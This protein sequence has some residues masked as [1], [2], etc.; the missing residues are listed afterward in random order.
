[1]FRQASGFT[2]WSR[3]AQDSLCRDY[4]VRSDLITVIPPGVRLDL[5]PFG[6]QP[7]RARPPGKPRVL[8]VGGD[9]ERKGGPLLLACMHAGLAE[10]CELDIV[11]SRPIPERPGVRAHYGLS[12][13]DPRLLAL[14]RDAD[15][16]AMPTQGDCLAVVLGEAMAAGL[17]VVTTTVAA[18]PEN[19]DDGR[20]GVLIPPADGDALGRALL[21]L[22]TDQD[23]RQR[24]GQAGRSIAE[25]RYDAARNADR[26]A[27]VVERAIMRWHRRRPERPSRL[28]GGG[29]S[30]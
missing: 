27:D 18:Q 4:G 19:V 16:F 11:T 7:R 1:V 2:V 10:W 3:W 20:S 22:A 12:P 26:I 17:P 13:N 8:F 9:F 30:C 21:R 24:M 6:A 29:R 14:Y 28:V 15:I 23:L 5:F 25:A